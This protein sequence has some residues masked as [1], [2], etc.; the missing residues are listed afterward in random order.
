M[1]TIL[2]NKKPKYFIG[3][4]N[5]QWVLSF[6]Q[7]SRGEWKDFSYFPKL[8]LLFED[9]AEELFRRNAKRINDI[10]QLDTLIQSVYDLIADTVGL[11]GSFY[12]AITPREVHTYGKD[13]NG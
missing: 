7:T 8:S 5:Y 1:K 4:D 3:S 6:K 13:K 12:E 2:V 11:E 9:L 10:T